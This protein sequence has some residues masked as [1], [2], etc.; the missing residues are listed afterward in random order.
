V[1]S[2]FAVAALQLFALKDVEEQQ[3][4]GL[5]AALMVADCMGC[6]EWLC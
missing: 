5:A 1:L 4:D 6:I 3:S 2:T